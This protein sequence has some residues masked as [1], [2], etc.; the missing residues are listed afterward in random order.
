[1]NYD[2]NVLEIDEDVP[3]GT[4][5]TY[6]GF[7]PT[8]PAD[9]QYS[10]TFAGWTPEIVAVNGNAAYTA[11]YT[12]NLE[13]AKI[14]FDLNGGTSESAIE[15]K[16]CDSIRASDFFFDVEKEGYNFRGW[17]FK[18]TKVFDQYGKQMSEPPI[19]ETMVFKA[20]FAQDVCLTISINIPGA[21]TVTGEGT[22][23]FNSNVDVSAVVKQGYS[24]VGWFY[25]GVL[26]S[27]QETYKY[28]MWDKD[29]I[30]E[31]RFS[32]KSFPLTVRSA[33]PELGLVMIKGDIVYAE[34]STKDIKYLSD[35]TVAAY[36]STETYRFLGWYDSENELLSTNAVYTFPMTNYALDLYAKWDSPSYEVSVQYESKMGSIDGGGDYPYYSTVDLSAAPNE[37]YRFVG[38]YDEDGELITEDDTYSFTMPLND[39][40]FTARFEAIVYSI[41]YDLNGGSLSAENP[42]EFTIEDKVTLN[43]PTKEHK[44]FIGWDDGN[45]NLFNGSFEGL[46][47]DLNLRAEWEEIYHDIALDYG[48]AKPVVTYITVHEGFPYELPIPESLG[49][50]FV[51]WYAG[52]TLVANSGI[53]DYDFKSLKAIWIHEFTVVDGKLSIIDKNIESIVIPDG[54]SAIND[55]TFEGCDKL[56][57]VSLPPTITKIGANAFKG[58]E[59]LKEISIPSSLTSIE[60]SAFQDCTS[61]ASIIIPKG[62]TSVGGSAFKGCKLLTSVVLPEGVTSIGDF[63][64]EGCTSLTSITIPDS[65]TSIGGSAF[66][67]CSSVASIT[68]PEGVTSIGDSA[69]KG[70]S[71]VSSITIPKGVT[72]IGEYTFFGCTSLTSITIPETV[73][74]I[75]DYAFSGC[76]SLTSIAIPKG[77]TSIDNS[78]FYGCKSLKSITIPETVTSIEDYAFSGCTSLTSI[79]IPK[80][81]TSID[82]SAF[83]GCKSLKSITIPESVTSISEWAFYR[84]TSLKSITI[85]ESVRSIGEY[86]FFGCTSLTSITI[87][88]SVRSIGNSGFSGCTSLTSIAIPKG[89]TSIGERTFQG[90]T[91]LTSITIPETV[92]SIGGYAFSGCTSLTSIA[93]PKGVTSIGEEAFSGCASLTSIAIPKGV[94]SIG[95]YTFFGCT[96]LTSITIPETVT[97]IGGYAFKGCSSLAS[98]TI[99]EGVASIG[100]YAFRGCSSLVSITIPEGV[101]SIGNY[102]FKGCSSL[103]SITIPESVRS[104]RDYAF[105]GCSSLTIYCVAKTKPVGWK[106]GWN[107]KRPVVWGYNPD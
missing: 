12:D 72:S 103:V 28:V 95:E 106:D 10:Y 74:S 75:E 92:T 19:E 45:G 20:D 21:G 32:I 63:V 97:S 93:I 16:L 14:V 90:C 76:T 68:I 62:V 77:V 17:S 34:S 66:S 43:S 94:T 89:V 55:S 67:G 53:W 35:V 29:I 107:A 49:Y 101:T 96:S 57:S 69:F 27:S 36:T 26:L 24:F 80:G 25:D 50:R 88:E 91:L 82:N 99:P 46:V 8:R 70:C 15:Y 47:G 85:P 104:I 58:C 40:N 83:Y 18:K 13:K 9:A 38:F 22:Y 52:E 1:L 87:P 105:E 11:R 81:V 37:G 6:D 23:P 4:T 31:A 65:V 102:A 56:S 30:L 71:S 48:D 60:S 3:F 84:C 42:T 54:I 79:A 73:T 98:I 33:Q 44:I 59:A 39:C 7:T 51:G 100:D 2:G 61:L 5:P 64:F 78:A 41:S 86:T